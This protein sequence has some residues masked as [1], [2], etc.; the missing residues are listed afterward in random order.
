MNK[1]EAFKWFCAGF[2]FAGEGYN[3]E[4]PFSWNKKK[5]AEEIKSNFEDYYDSEMN[6]YHKNED[7]EI[8]LDK[9]VEK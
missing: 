5:I 1:E 2:T 4:Y 7:Y 6:P 3:G 8:D 9:E